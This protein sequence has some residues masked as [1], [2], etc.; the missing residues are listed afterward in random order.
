ME[1]RESDAFTEVRLTLPR[2]SA[3]LLVQHLDAAVVPGLEGYFET[4]YTENQTGDST[5]LYFYFD[6]ADTTASLK[7]EL[8]A[9]ASGAEEMDLESR[10]VSRQE[11]L[12]SYKKHYTSFRIADFAIVPSWKQSEA[13]AFPGAQLLFLDPGLAFGT[14]LHPTT[15]MCLGWISSHRELIRAKRII[16]AGTGSG[17][18]SLA[19]LLAGA[20]RV[21]AFDLESNAI[22]ATEQNLLLNSN[23]A[24]DRLD[25]EL[26]GFEIESF[27][28]FRGEILV[29][30]LTAS[31][32]L[33][34]KE[35]I[36][37]GRFPRMIFTGILSEQKEE[38]RK[39]FSDWQLVSSAEEDGWALLELGLSG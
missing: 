20:G 23:L 15:R 25:L 39:A 11:Y 26:G 19:L 8:L 2:S 5:S 7:V 6:P 38:V 14:G 17:I 27:L 32:I 16:D 22:R 18:L 31:I 29:G 10:T 9:A 30:N 36:Q 1:S 35:R 4:L 12:E 28:S 34:A 37:S 3:Q 13:D 21:L 33:G 24:R